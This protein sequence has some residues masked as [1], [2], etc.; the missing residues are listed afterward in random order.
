MKCNYLLLGHDKGDVDT[1]RGVL[2]RRPLPCS[3]VKHRHCGQG[4]LHTIT[5]ACHAPQLI[6]VPIDGVVMVKLEPEHHK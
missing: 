4:L 2:W 5:V 6:A 3:G 1:V